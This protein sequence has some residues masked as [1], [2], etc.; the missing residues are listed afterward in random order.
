MIPVLNIVYIYIS[1]LV[2]TER[3]HRYPRAHRE[4]GQR[5]LAHDMARKRVLHRH[6]NQD[7]RL[8]QGSKLYINLFNDTSII[9]SKYKLY[10]QRVLYNINFNYLRRL[11]LTLSL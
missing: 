1:E 7:I 8:Y 11:S 10:V 6:V 5:F 3:L 4:H 2:E 9:Y